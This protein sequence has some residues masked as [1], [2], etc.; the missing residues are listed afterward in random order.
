MILNQVNFVSLVD[1]ERNYFEASV[2]VCRDYRMFLFLK[3]IG[4]KWRFFISQMEM[5]MLS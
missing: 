5:I 4:V 2:T 3:W 1:N